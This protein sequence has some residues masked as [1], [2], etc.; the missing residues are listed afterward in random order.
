MIEKITLR[1]I[2][3]KAKMISKGTMNRVIILIFIVQEVW[4]QGVNEK[5]SNHE[6]LEKH[7]KTI[8]TSLTGLL[9]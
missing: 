6:I 5:H 3:M 9:E 4:D 8:S 7:E 2:G 1:R